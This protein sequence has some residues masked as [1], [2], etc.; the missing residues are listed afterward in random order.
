MYRLLLRPDYSLRVAMIDDSARVG[1]MRRLNKEP[2][3]RYYRPRRSIPT[4]KEPSVK[5][6]D[7]GVST[8][9]DAA[10]PVESEPKNI[11]FP[12]PASLSAV[13]RLLGQGFILN[14]RAA[15]PII[16]GLSVMRVLNSPNPG[17]RTG[18]VTSSST[19]LRWVELSK[20]SEAQRTGPLL[21]T[22]PL[23][24]GVIRTGI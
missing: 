11:R 4:L 12:A 2:W 7:C 6:S 17:W 14:T 21:R 13:H 3:E 22:Y 8:L 24:G 18:R 5:S 19:P 23:D 16:G 1:M 15:A 10:P 20:T 9:L